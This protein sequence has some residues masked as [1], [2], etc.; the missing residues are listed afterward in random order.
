ML[1]LL[2]IQRDSLTQGYQGSSALG[3]IETLVPAHVG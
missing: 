2:R 3:L 1:M